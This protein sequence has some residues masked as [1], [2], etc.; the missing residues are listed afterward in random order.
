MTYREYEIIFSQELTRKELTSGMLF[1]QDYKNDCL[2]YA[3][4]LF[5]KGV[6]LI[7]DIEHFSM[8]VGYTTKYIKKA[9]H[10][11]NSYYWTYKIPKKNGTYRYI[12]EPMPNL[13][14]IQLWILNH[15]LYSQTFHP[16]AKAYVPHKTIRDNIKFHTKHDI[17]VTLDIHDF[18]SSIKREKIQQV[19]ESLGYTRV[20]SN[21]FSKL[22]CIN[23][24]LPQGAP[25]SPA[26]SNMYMW[27]FDNIVKSYCGEKKIWYT[28]YADD[29]TFS[30]TF[31]KDE[32]IDFVK[33]KLILFDLKINAEKT[34][35][36]NKNQRQVVTGCV[37]NQKTHL[38]KEDL[39]KIRQVVYYL[40]KFGLDNHL[41]YIKESRRHYL[42]YWY[43]KITYALLVQPGNKE[44][45]EYKKF[46]K[47]NYREYL[48]DNGAYTSEE[49]DF[50]F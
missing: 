28:R 33:E 19:F 25:T 43:G 44:M 8:L 36:M 9:I 29:M 13:K 39:K 18:F 27:D 50:P 14:D 45:K 15:I 20:L 34:R 42:N 38:P 3:K 10:F 32:L 30:G 31:D 21:M 2:L 17:V 16:Y 22:C 41:Q 26:L 49:C 23:E 4:M 37:V 47:E 11:P 6:P 40:K 48:E 46:F 5:E 12:M 7:Y 24:S 35:V 1:P